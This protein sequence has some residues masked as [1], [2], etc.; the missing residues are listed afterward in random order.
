VA[1]AQHMA[2]RLAASLDSQHIGVKSIYLF[3]STNDGTAAGE[4]TSI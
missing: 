4:A 1:L 3:G 2:E